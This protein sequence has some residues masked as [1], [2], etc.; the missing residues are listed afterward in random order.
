M[1]NKRKIESDD[2]D[3]SI[4]I[5]SVQ[6]VKT[7]K[8]TT[9]GSNNNTEDESLPSFISTPSARERLTRMEEEFQNIA[10]RDRINKY[11]SSFTSYNNMDFSS[12][13]NDP[14]ALNN[15]SPS[16]STL[17]SSW[18]GS[19]SS[20]SLNSATSLTSAELLEKQLMEIHDLTDEDFKAIAN[21]DA[22]KF[23]D[24]NVE[25]CFVK[26]PKVK[27]VNNRNVTTSPSTI[28]PTFGDSIN[29]DSF[30]EYIQL[31]ETFNR[32]MTKL[33]PHKSEK[34]LTS[35]LNIVDYMSRR[36]GVPAYFFD[37]NFE[38]STPTYFNK[39]FSSENESASLLLQ[40]KLS[41]YLDQVENQVQTQVNKRS[42]EIF[43]SMM[44]YNDLY[45]TLI[46]SIPLVGSLRSKIKKYEENAVLKP[47]EVGNL[48][49]KKQNLTKTLEYIVLIDSIQQSLTAVKVMVANRGD[50][51]SALEIINTIESTLQE[52]SELSN[53]NCLKHIPKEIEVELGVIDMTI[54]QEISELIAEILQKDTTSSDWNTKLASLLKATLYRNLAVPVMAHAK[55][56][57]PSETEE[58]MKSIKPPVFTPSTEVTKDLADSWCKSFD[59]IV[60]LALIKLQRFTDFCF[61]VDQ[62]CKEENEKADSSTDK[63]II[64]TVKLKNLGREVAKIQSFMHE[65]TQ[66][67]LSNFCSG[68]DKV[69]SKFSPTLFSTY[70]A[71]G[72]KFI[73]KSDSMVYKKC[74]ILKGKLQHH[75]QVFLDDFHT[76]YVQRL[77]KRL[78][79][80]TWEAVPSIPEKYQKCAFLL[81]GEAQAMSLPPPTTVPAST[82]SQ[83]NAK[84]AEEDKS[85][86]ILANGIKFKLSTSALCLLKFIYQYSQLLSNDF[87]FISAIDLHGRILQ[88]LQVYNSELKEL[89]LMAKAREVNSA[90]TSITPKHL[91]LASDCLHYLILLMPYIQSKI[92]TAL[93]EG[94]KKQL[95]KFGDFITDLLEHRIAIFEKIVSILGD[96]LK[97]QLS[98]IPNYNWT[99][100]NDK[101]PTPFITMCKQ[102]NSVYRTLGS[103][104]FL[105]SDQFEQKKYSKRVYD[106]L[107]DKICEAFEQINNRSPEIFRNEIVKNRASSDLVVIQKEIQ[108]RTDP[109]DPPRFDKLTKLL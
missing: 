106:M 58:L 47:L 43:D 22:R 6:T 31:I 11:Y 50:V 63:I 94:Q 27:N 57:V 51:L 2:D 87:S 68:I 80:D 81:T 52:H 91:I 82:T 75:G 40:E 88:L 49:R 14:K 20:S 46:S 29:I 35:N 12:V 37:E 108:K 73:T 44:Q 74:T 84:T 65:S 24:V 66:Q 3:F 56:L 33:V 34:S 99:N 103:S 1:E 69:I 23:E 39:V 79:R 59:S 48:V 70:M 17:F 10:P 41:Y 86:Y 100:V 62:F 28:S 64:N 53:V 9:A 42:S 18:F 107:I 71:T 15:S 21:V 90:I 4:E 19:S 95:V 97:Y 98:E 60:S 54:K 92:E 101:N 7:N 93:Q 78:A 8:T 13:L 72:S 105:S 25:S 67:Q 26:N 76:T 102:A 55:K 85:S 77:K 45:E 83:K 5:L 104:T 32:E 30:K 61:A 36:E 109:N 89:V 38:L 16:L 96:A